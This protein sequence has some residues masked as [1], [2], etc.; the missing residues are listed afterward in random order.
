LEG[1]L[2]DARAFETEFE[3]LKQMLQTKTVECSEW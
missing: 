3:K 2:S 1:S